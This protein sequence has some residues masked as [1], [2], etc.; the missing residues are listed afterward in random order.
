[1]RQDLSSSSITD[2][3]IINSARIWTDDYEYESPK[4]IGKG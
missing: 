1:V 4:L 2:I 3:E